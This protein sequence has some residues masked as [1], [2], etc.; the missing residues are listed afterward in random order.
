MDLR[1]RYYGGAGALAL[2]LAFGCISIVAVWPTQAAD[3]TRPAVEAADEAEQ[4][5]WLVQQIRRFRSH[6]HLDR[7]YRLERAGRLEEARAEM[8]KALDADPGNVQARIDYVALLERLGE[9]QEVLLQTEVLLK[10]GE[11]RPD[12]MMVRARAFRALDLVDEARAALK[13]VLAAQRASPDQKTYAADALGDIELKQGNY[14]DALDALA[15]LPRGS[16][17]VHLRRG[18]AIEALQRYQEAAREF[19]HALRLAETAADRAM[20]LAYLGHNAMQREDWTQAHAR[21]DAALALDPGNVALM[22]AI[23][24]AA[25]RAGRS[26]EALRW[27]ADVVKLEPTVADREVVANLRFATGDYQGAVRD[28]QALLQ[29][30]TEPAKQAR[31]HAAIG[32]AWFEL[33]RYADA[34]RAFEEAVRQRE[35][36]HWLQALEAARAQGRAPEMD[37]MAALQRAVQTEPTAQGHLQLAMLLLEQGEE[38]GAILHF[39]AATGFRNAGKARLAAYRQLWSLYYARGQADAARRALEGLLTLSPKDA[40]ALRAIAHIAIE[41]GDTA[42]AVAYLWRSVEVAPSG[43]NY[44]A[45]AYAL[46]TMKD[47]EGAVRANRAWLTTKTLTDTERAEAY[48]RLAIAYHETGD[49][50]ATLRTLKAALTDGVDNRFIR[51]RL[52]LALSGKGSWREALPH[53][54]AL[55]EDAPT[56]LAALYLARCYSAIGK[57]GLAVHYGREAL[58]SDEPLPPGEREQLQ[59]ALAFLYADESEFDGAA[60]MW[61]EVI[62][63]DPQPINI[64]RYGVAQH[65]AGN[66]DEARATWEA[67]ADGVLPK[68]EEVERLNHLAMFRS[69]AG[70]LR[71]A[72]ALYRKAD[73]LMPGAYNQYRIGLALQELGERDA[74]I[75]AFKLALAREYKSGYALALGYAYVNAGRHAEAAPLLAEASERD[76]DNLSLYQDVAYAYL[77]AFDNDKAVEWF[78]RGIDARLTR[79][80]Q[81]A[82]EAAPAEKAAGTPPPDATRESDTHS[83]PRKPAL[84]DKMVS[85]DLGRYAR[86]AFDAPVYESSATGDASRL[87]QGEP[88]IGLPQHADP[89]LERMRDEVRRLEKNWNFILYQAYSPGHDRPQAGVPSTGGSVLPSQGGLEISYRP[90]VVGFRDERIFDIYFRALWANEPRSLDMDSDSLQGGIGLRYKPLRTIQLYLS[91]ERLF[92]IGDEAQNTWLLRTSYGWTDMYDRKFGGE[93]NWNYSSLYADLG[94]F[95][96]DDHTRAFYGEARQGRTFKIGEQWLVS[97]HFIVNGRYEQPNFSP[98]SYWQAGAGVSVKYLF[99][100]TKYASY[101]SNIELLLHYKVGMAHVASGWLFTFVARL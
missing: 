27:A 8:A 55:Y 92:K 15:M 2:A 83:A 13:Q 44:R 48:E 59:A 39:E 65:R 84:D 11:R 64:Y 71:G 82:K 41:Q 72:I 33:E 76:P 67:I 101:R 66:L 63:R 97:P 90:P 95:T 75:E 52:A 29:E 5:N 88:A 22:R 43:E 23:A 61:A 36:P 74:S 78:K 54:R 50:E 89:E 94:V 21:Y 91:G 28:Y 1:Q 57:T 99:N 14:A 53:F 87:A 10:D 81:R 62:E 16:F 18:I 24:Q 51:E 35:E 100:A 79:S 17:R 58:Q 42:A 77:K 25:H 70:D 49:E 9:T 32:Y 4:P 7:S 19:E 30:T 37:T 69:A 86:T 73:A 47:W 68:D 26:R 45:L 20:V 85:L 56:A 60:R 98:G 31:L 80:A 34:A 93:T 12:A 40:Q 3:E 96:D 46:A 38:D 6:P